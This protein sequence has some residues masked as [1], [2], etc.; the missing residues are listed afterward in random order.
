VVKVTGRPKDRL[1]MIR[2]TIQS[3]DRQVPVF[4]VETMEQRMAEWFARPQFYKT[5]VMFFAAFA[6]LLAII[7][8][9]GIVSYTVARRHHEMGV[10]MALGVTAKKLRASLLRQGL[11]PVFAGAVPGVAVAILMDHLLKSLVEEAKPVA[12]AVYI[13]SVLFIALVAAA[14]I[15]V[16]TKPVTRLDIADILRAE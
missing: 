9:H 4:G 5:A 1:A 8:I 11:I 10:R 2:D 13:G 14:G 15:W 16:A 6:F 3:V 7:G 12:P